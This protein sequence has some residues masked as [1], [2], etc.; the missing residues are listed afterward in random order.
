MTQ[1]RDLGVAAKGGFGPDEV[2]R[3][4]TQKL[5]FVS[6]NPAAPGRRRGDDDLKTD[7]LMPP[8]EAL[9]AAAVLVPI[10]AHAQ[11]AQVL[12]TQ[13]PEHL[14][15]HPGQIAFPGGRVEDHDDSVIAA[16]LREAEE[17]IGLTSEHIT[18]RGTLDV[19]RTISG[20]RITPVV[21]V[22]R[23]GFHLRLD[24]NEVD[25]AFEVPLSFLMDPANHARHS[26]FSRGRERHFYAMPYHDHYIWGATAGM[27]VN[28][29]DKL[30]GPG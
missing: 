9:R 4:L 29:Y 22:V 14:S 23:P 27:L 15:K 19:Y 3:L 20:F 16:A 25:E 12:L 2:D 6:L 5:D 24:P 21:A 18:V 17:E 7:D 13:R 11:G 26:R 28:L 1:N 8:E 10:V 30:Y